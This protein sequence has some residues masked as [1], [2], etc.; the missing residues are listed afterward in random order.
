MQSLDR[1]SQM[2]FDKDDEN[3][4]NEKIACKIVSL[5]VI[6]RVIKFVPCDLLEFLPDENS[7]ESSAAN[8][9][10]EE[11]EV[12]LVANLISQ[13]IISFLIAEN[14]EDEE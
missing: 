6:G 13:G 14:H 10:S 7:S 9:Q 5:R 1:A 4:H 8:Q 3:D 12:Q 2:N 11:E